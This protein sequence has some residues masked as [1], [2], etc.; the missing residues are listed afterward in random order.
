MNRVALVAVFSGLLA[1]AAAWATDRSD[2]YPL[3]VQILH[4]HAKSPSK[5]C[6][7][8]DGYTHGAGYGNLLQDDGSRGFRYAYAC[9]AKMHSNSNGET[10]AARWKKSEAKLT[11]LVPA[12]DKPGK[13]WTCDLDIEMK[14]FAFRSDSLATDTLR[15][16]LNGHVSAH[17]NGSGD[18][19]TPHE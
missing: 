14:H 3:R 17:P 16:P 18:K 7:L 12:A 2:S 1:S 10:Y 11:V 6:P 15:A 9:S 13:F 8:S 19:S 4:A 5:S